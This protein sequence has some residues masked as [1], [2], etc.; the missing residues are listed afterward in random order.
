M[1]KRGFTIIE[2]IAVIAILSVLLLIGF[3]GFRYYKSHIQR[4]K[5][6]SCVYDVKEF[7]SFSKKY[8]YENRCSGEIYFDC[9]D[10]FTKVYLVCRGKIIKQLDIL[11]KLKLLNS[12]CVFD[13]K[14]CV[15]LKVS[16]R[17]YVSAF[18][19]KITNDDF[20]KEIIIQV[21]GNLIYIKDG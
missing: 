4:M 21:G 2:I 18:T 9:C 15:L 5:C 10:D 13:D 11:E 1:K 14:R 3:K 7:L 6:I 8:C 12:N 16:M 19:L 20:I 17:G